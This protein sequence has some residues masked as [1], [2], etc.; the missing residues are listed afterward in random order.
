VTTMKMMKSATDGVVIN[1]F[2]PLEHPVAFF[3]HRGRLDLR[4]VGAA[5]HARDRK[6]AAD[7]AAQVGPQPPSFAARP[8]WRSTRRCRVRRHIAEHLHR[9]ADASGDQVHLCSAAGRNHCAPSSLGDV[10]PI[11]T[12]STCCLSGSSNRAASWPIAGGAVA[13]AAGFF[14]R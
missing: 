13:P 2:A 5:T 12:G 10:R 9:H 6:G 8:A 7:L 14:E 3:E 4:R 11:V 1:P